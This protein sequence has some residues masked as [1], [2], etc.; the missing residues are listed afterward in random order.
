[1]I[2]FV[3]GTVANRSVVGIGGGTMSFT[4]VGQRNATRTRSFSFDREKKFWDKSWSKTLLKQK[5]KPEWC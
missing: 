3:K 4:S 5:G 1:L 2:R